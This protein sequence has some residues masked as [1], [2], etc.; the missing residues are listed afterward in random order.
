[1]VELLTAYSHPAQASDLPFTTLWLSLT[2]ACAPR[3]NAKH[4]RSRRDRLDES[5]MITAY[6]EGGTAASL[7]TAAHGL[8]SPASSSLARLQR[9]SNSVALPLA[10]QRGRQ[11]IG[12]EQPHPSDPSWMI[13][14]RSLVLS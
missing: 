3:S 14:A 13:T 2:P 12:I 8:V 7:A 5:D 10:A 9:R 11:C 4:P 1:M 6:R